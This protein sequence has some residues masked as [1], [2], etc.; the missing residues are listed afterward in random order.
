MRKDKKPA[1]SGCNTPKCITCPS[2]LRLLSNESPGTTRQ[3]Q[4]PNLH[5]TSPEALHPEEDVNRMTASAMYNRPITHGNWAS[6]LLWG[7]NSTSDGLIWNGYL[8]ESTLR[9]AERNFVWGRIESADRTSELLL[10]N[11][12][13]PPGFRESIIGRVQ[14]YSAG[15]DRDFLV[16]H[17]AIAPG[18]QF[19]VYTTPL[20]LKAQY[21]SHPAGVVVF[22]RIRPIGRQR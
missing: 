12:L 18:A 14:A 7:R 17:L 22:L 21:G 3:A 11:Q 5:L 6:T 8:A 10:R 1:W 2:N 13:E 9:F 15:Y 4:V 20:A 16:R 19:T